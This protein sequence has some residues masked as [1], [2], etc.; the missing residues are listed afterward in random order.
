MLEKINNEVFIYFCKNPHNSIHIRELARLLEIS[1]PKCIG[2]IKKLG[3]LLL[4]KRAGKSILISANLDEKFIYY[5]KWAN[6]F[7]FLESGILK[8]LNK[9]DPDSIILFGSYARGED[10][11]KSDIDVALDRTIKKDLSKFE[12]KLNRRIQFHN[13]SKKI[14]KHLAENIR[15]GILVE[16]VMI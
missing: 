12:K 3:D 4:Q 15:Q 2:L 7:I 8:E 5:K 9:E 13:I 14:N 10:N 16:G 6:I 1:P 11:E